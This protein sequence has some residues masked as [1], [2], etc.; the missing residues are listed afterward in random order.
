MKH[1]HDEALTQTRDM[2]TPVIILKHEIL[3]V[4][5]CV[6]VVSVIEHVF[7][8]KCWCYMG[9]IELDFV[10]SSAKVIVLKLC[11]LE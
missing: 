1:Y 7:D 4:T 2:L 11:L 10:L 3:N 5:G 6:V 8:V 9:Y